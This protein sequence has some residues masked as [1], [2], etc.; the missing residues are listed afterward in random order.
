MYANIVQR[1]SAGEL[2]TCFEMLTS[3]PA[4][5]QGRGDYGIA[6]GNPADLVVWD[7]KSAEDAIA[8]VA[9][10]LFSLKG[11]R[12]VFTRTLAELHRP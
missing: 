3:R 1:G 6:A 7:A 2:A 9:Q 8:T 10:S 12:R 5:L 11:G 4:R